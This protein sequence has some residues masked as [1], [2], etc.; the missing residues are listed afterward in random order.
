MI[1]VYVTNDAKLAQKSRCANRSVCSDIRGISDTGRFL[2]DVN[3]ADELVPPLSPLLLLIWLQCIV[4]RGVST[5]RAGHSAI[6]DAHI[7]PSVIDPSHQR[8]SICAKRHSADPD[9]LVIL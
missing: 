6:G 4:R 7:S 9:C 2:L 3:G 5:G 8:R 1:H